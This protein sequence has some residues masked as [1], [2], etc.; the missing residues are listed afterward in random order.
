MFN[1]QVEDYDAAANI[2]DRRLFLYK[3]GSALYRFQT[4]EDAD[5]DRTMVTSQLNVIDDASAGD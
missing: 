1:V 3:N 5:T 2:T 4:S